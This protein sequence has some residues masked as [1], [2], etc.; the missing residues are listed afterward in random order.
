[1]QALLPVTFTN[2]VDMAD[3]PKKKKADGKKVSQQKHEVDYLVKQTGKTPAA[4]KKA[5]KDAGPGRAEVKKA[6][7]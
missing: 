2:G 3:D 5:I 6:L 4:V 7:K 1:V